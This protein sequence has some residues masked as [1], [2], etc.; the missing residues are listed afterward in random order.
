MLESS[1]EAFVA[2]ARI[3]SNH[4]MTDVVDHLVATM[5]AFVTKGAQRAVEMNR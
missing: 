5:Y 4:R 2:V 1:V 3:A